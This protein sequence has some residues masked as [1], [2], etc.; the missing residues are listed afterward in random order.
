MYGTGTEGVSEMK[1]R[2][3]IAAVGLVASM[4]ITA[5]ASTAGA[6]TPTPVTT[7]NAYGGFISLGLLNTIG[8]SGGGSAADSTTGGTTDASGTGLCLTLAST[9]NPC[10]TDATTPLSSGVLISTTQ[11]ASTSGINGTGTPTP[12]TA[13]LLPLNLGLIDADV[14]CGTASA[15]TDGLGFPTATGEGY[16]GKVTVSLDLDQLGLGGLLGTGTV[17]DLCGTSS[18][19]T[20]TT[21]VPQSIVSGLLGSVN[22][23]LGGVGDGLLPTSILSSSSSTGPLSGVCSILSGLTGELGGVGGLL[24]GLTGTSPLLSITLGDSTSNVS[25]TDAAGSDPMETATATTEALDVNLLGLL[26]VKLLPNSATIAIDTVTGAVSFPSQ[27]TVGVLQVTPLGGA[28]LG[29]NLPDLNGA[30]SGLID[31]LSSALG[32]VLGDAANPTL[33]VAPATTSING[34]SGMA[35]AADLKL[36]LLG[37]LVVLNVGDASVTAGWTN[38]T[39]APKT[40]AATTPVAKAAAPIAPAAVPS[41]PGVTTVHTGEFWAGTLPIF[42]MSGMALGGLMLIARRRVFSMARSVISIRRRR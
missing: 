24:S 28:P 30:L 17:G 40:L 31:S 14:A 38:G 36:D 27:P 35:E 37:G 1:S 19:S 34:T 12:S 21:A 11:R 15:T 33:Q 10:P 7:V 26:D 25:S 22:T 8:L 41:V 18:T 9:T 20:G 32:N 3:R 5:M 29:L 16:L 42:L 13:C 4:A 23:L 39:P 2:I 6:A